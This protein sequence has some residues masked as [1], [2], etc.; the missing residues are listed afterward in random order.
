M[1]LER[2]LLA[3][4]NERPAVNPMRIERM[5]AINASDAANLRRATRYYFRGVVELTEIE[6]GRTLVA[7][8][9]V[10]ELI[11]LFCENQSILQLGGKAAA[12]DDARRLSFF[13]NRARRKPNGDRHWS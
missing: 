1:N 5:P 11:R 3:D 9:P 13:G 6:S 8:R 7:S 12:E 10:A 2:T 4:L